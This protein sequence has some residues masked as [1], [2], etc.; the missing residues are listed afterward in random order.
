LVR[1]GFASSVGGDQT[2]SFQNFA[3]FLNA[4]GAVTISQNFSVPLQAGVALPI[5]G[6]NFSLE[7]FGGGAINNRNVEL[8][9]T[10]LSAPGG[11]P[12][13]RRASYTTV[14]PAAGLGVRYYVP[15]SAISVG[16]DLNFDFLRSQDVSV[17]SAN[18][19]TQTYI[20]STGDQVNVTASLSANI[21]LNRMFREEISSPRIFNFRRAILGIR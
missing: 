14:D 2:A 1:T 17:R 6:S 4:N 10:E 3:G 12:T 15:D 13:R 7:I 19:P 20:A 9:L 5:S 21:D 11:P 18:F 16:A 8:Q